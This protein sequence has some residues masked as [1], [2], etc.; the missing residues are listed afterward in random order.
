MRYGM[1]IDVEACAGC[2]A[3]TIAC[4]SNNNLPNGIRY[5]NVLTVGGGAYLDTA[6]GTYPY[7]LHK[8]HYTVGCQHCTNAPC[9]DVCPTGATYKREDGIVAVNA[10][11][12]IGCGA[13]VKRC[14]MFAITM[15]DDGTCE[16]NRQC[17]R[18][19]Q[20]A[21]VCPVSARS[22]VAKPLE[23]QLELPED[24]FDDYHQ[25]SQ[26]RMAEGFITDFVG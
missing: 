8:K 24:M 5:T 14:P 18:C 17:V 11:A 10:E 6:S 15:N 13:C 19:G 23:Q 12:C 25:F 21:L 16:M 4:K 9:V 20:C 2:H 1:A 22:L 26:L 7:D 3:C